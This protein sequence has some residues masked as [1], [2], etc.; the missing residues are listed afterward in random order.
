MRR[1]E[2]Q[3]SGMGLN[4][5]AGQRCVVTTLHSVLWCQHRHGASR[6]IAATSRPSW[7]RFCDNSSVW[8]G[9]QSMDGICKTW[10]RAVVVIASVI[11]SGCATGGLTASG[12]APTT[13][14]SAR[15]NAA[16]NTAMYQTVSYANVATK[17]PAVIVLPGEVKRNNAT[18]SQRYDPNNIAD[19]AEL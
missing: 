1:A 19:Y 17:G 11:L 2:H 10:L 9:R 15:A 14:A 3:R 6:T 8:T 5:G 12:P 16:A 18:F 7:H 13:G 4:Q